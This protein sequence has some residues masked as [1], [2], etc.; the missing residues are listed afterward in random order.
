M[1]NVL[2]PLIYMGIDQESPIGHIEDLTFNFLATTSA[3]PGVNSYAI[4]V[5]S[6]DPWLMHSIYFYANPN[7]AAGLLFLKPYDGDGQEMFTDF[8]LSNSG[9]G[10]VNTEPFPLLPPRPFRPNDLLRFDI[11]D[12]FG[13]N[14]FEVLFRGY[15]IRGVNAPGGTMAGT[16]GGPR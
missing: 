10:N 4:N 11:L 12:R 13:N 14:A 16:M 1:T 8:F 7:L 2:A 6:D 15:S 5:S 9:I 3:T